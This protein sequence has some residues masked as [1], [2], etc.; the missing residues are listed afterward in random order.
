MIVSHQ[1][2]LNKV[3]GGRSLSVCFFLFFF[4]LY[5]FCTKPRVYT[6]VRP[7]SH[8]ANI[9]LPKTKNDR[10]Q[11]QGKQKIV[12]EHQQRISIE[13]LQKI[14]EIYPLLER[15]QARSTMSIGRQFHSGTIL[16]EKEDGC[17]VERQI[18]WYRGRE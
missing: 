8:V 18:G 4:Y 9:R 13:Q 7:P 5:E 11:K 1:G 3:W 16:A 2:C 10:K 17:A 15:E 12:C 14:K 6:R